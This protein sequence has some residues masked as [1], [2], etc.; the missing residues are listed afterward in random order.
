MS[1]GDCLYQPS[2]MVISA[3]LSHATKCSKCLLTSSQVEMESCFQL[4]QFESLL[5]PE[6][7]RPLEPTVLLALKELF[8]RSNAN[9]TAL[10]MLSVDCQVALNHV[11][12]ESAQ[13][14]SVCLPLLA[15]AYLKICACFVHILFIMSLTVTTCM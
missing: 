1:V 5:L 8:N 12:V 15:F 7:N 9:T 11:Q 4:D 13:V 14:E 3:E 6:N 2:L 10:H